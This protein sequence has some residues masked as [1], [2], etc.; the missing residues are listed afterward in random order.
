[1][2]AGAPVTTVLRPRQPGSARSPSH[3]SDGA[4]GARTRVVQ[5]GSDDHPRRLRRSGCGGSCQIRTSGPAPSPEPT[6]HLY[7]PAPGRLGP[8]SMGMLPED[9]ERRF[10]TNSTT[11]TKP[12]S[13]D[14]TPLTRGGEERRGET[15][16]CKAA[17]SVG[18]EGTERA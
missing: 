16:G 9:D 2:A 15:G 17:R 18:P 11:Q 8:S 3:G 12:H 13:Q 7:W 6:L 14:Q 1:M 10:V 5:V 4:A